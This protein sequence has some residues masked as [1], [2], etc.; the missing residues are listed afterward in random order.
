MKTTTTV[1]NLQGSDLTLTYDKHALFRYGRAGGQLNLILVTG[2]EFFQQVLLIWSA[3]DDAARAR[4]PDPALLVDL[5][6]PEDEALIE[7]ILRALIEAGWLKPQNQDRE[8][9]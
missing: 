4:Y 5:I 3:L 6:D 7:Q 2:Q 9:L 1:I 8:A